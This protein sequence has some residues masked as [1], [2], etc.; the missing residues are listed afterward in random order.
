MWRRLASPSPVMV[1]ACCITK[2]LCTVTD[3]AHG[4]EGREITPPGGAGGDRRE[5]GGARVIG[6]GRVMPSIL[7]LLGGWRE[8]PM[9]GGEA[10]GAMGQVARLV[11]PGSEMLR[12][13]ESLRLS[14]A[15]ERSPS[16]SM[17][18]S[19]APLRQLA[20]TGR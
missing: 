19:P 3:S 18:W 7:H 17:L 20:S 16:L 15:P 12:L 13:K 5:E 4:E 2:V 11:W 8:G 14:L 6:L 9:E 1:E 10:R